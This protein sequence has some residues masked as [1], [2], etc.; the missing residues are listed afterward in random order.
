MAGSQNDMREARATHDDYVRSVSHPRSLP[1][2]GSVDAFENSITALQS[3]LRPDIG[4]FNIDFSIE[5]IMPDQK[6]TLDERIEQIES[7]LGPALYRE[8]LER[9]ALDISDISSSHGTTT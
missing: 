9:N 4:A 3:F 1:F 6:A 7:E 5:N 2:F 8:L